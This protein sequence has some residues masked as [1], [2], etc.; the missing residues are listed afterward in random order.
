MTHKDSY[1]GSLCFGSLDIVFPVDESGLRK[2]P[3][4]C[5]SCAHLKAC[6]QKA[7][8]GE[9]G[10]RFNEERIDRAYRHGLIGAFRRWSEKK[11]IRRKIEEFKKK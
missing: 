9:E 7:M 3:N 4:N 6:L 8:Q 11:H 10:L 2:I 1:S 5:F